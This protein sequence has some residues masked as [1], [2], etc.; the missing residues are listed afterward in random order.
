MPETLNPNLNGVAETLLL[1]HQ[2][3]VCRQLT[4][5]DVKKAASVLAEA[6]SDEAH[7]SF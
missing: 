5:L 1:P 6:F 2:G 7:P 4:P 3:P